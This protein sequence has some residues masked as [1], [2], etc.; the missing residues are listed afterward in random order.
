L[1]V[2]SWRRRER[3]HHCL[4][5]L[6][7]AIKCSISIV[8]RSVTWSWWCLQADSWSVSTC[9]FPHSTLAFCREPPVPL[10]LL[11]LMLIPLL[12]FC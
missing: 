9:P 2:A 11:I 8:L 10:A 5:N 1:A 12:R 4:E 6:N 7:I 3:L